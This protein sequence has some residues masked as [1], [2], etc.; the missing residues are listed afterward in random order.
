MKPSVVSPFPS[1]PPTEKVAAARQQG[2]DHD[3]AAGDEG[4]LHD[5]DSATTVQVVG[6]QVQVVDYTDL[7]SNFSL[8]YFFEGIFLYIMVC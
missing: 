2:N 5:D 7:P 3:K 4:P 6:V 8:H 1:L